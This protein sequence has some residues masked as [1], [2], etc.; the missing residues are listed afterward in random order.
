MAA[1]SSREG[2][3]ATAR[4]E[5]Q[6][7]CCWC[8]L[9]AAY[10]LH[11]D[12]LVVWHALPLPRQQ[13]ARAAGARGVHPLVACSA[14]SP[15]VCLLPNCVTKNN[16]LIP[17]S[18]PPIALI[19]LPPA[20]GPMTAVLASGCQLLASSATWACCSA[21]AS[22][23]SSPSSVTRPRQPGRGGAERGQFCIHRCRHL[24][25]YSTARRLQQGGA[26]GG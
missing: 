3:I 19:N 6:G 22:R 18:F 4:P 14:P 23:C 7:R 12:W 20:L 1:G 2:P 15:P 13:P 11:A 21:R 8:C 26:S 25:G 10:M 9:N 5:Q 16:A 17:L 24:T